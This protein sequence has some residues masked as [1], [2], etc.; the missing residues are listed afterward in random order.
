MPRPL[1]RGR[2]TSPLL[3]R[4]R[5]CGCY[6]RERSEKSSSR[7]IS[8]V[9]LPSKP[10]TQNPAPNAH[11]RHDPRMAIGTSGK[12]QKRRSRLVGCVS[13]GISIIRFRRLE[14]YSRSLRQ[15]TIS[16]VCSI[17]SGMSSERITRHSETARCQAI[18][19]GGM[20][21]HACTK[22]TLSPQNFSIR[23]RASVENPVERN[24]RRPACEPSYSGCRSR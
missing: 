20:R 4:K 7:P 10:S 21:L 11:A 22:G 6:S 24:L 1:F 3:S 5:G 14:G 8:H 16:R 23:G 13:S 9:F 12:P 2:Q 17:R 15:A 19:V 18:S